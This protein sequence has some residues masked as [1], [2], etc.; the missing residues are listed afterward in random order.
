[1]N[2]ADMVLKMLT[3]TPL[4]NTVEMAD[5]AKVKTRQKRKRDTK[6]SIFGPEKWA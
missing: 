3:D 4:E 2:S 1:M 5:M 6:V